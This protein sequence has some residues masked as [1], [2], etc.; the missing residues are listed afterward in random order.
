MTPLDTASVSSVCARCAKRFN[1]CCA[2]LPGNEEVCFPLSLGEAQRMSD[3]GIP[4]QSVESQPNTQPFIDCM[5][6]LFPADTSTIE[7]TFPLGKVHLR[8]ASDQEGRCKLLSPS[9]CMLPGE[10]RPWYCRL[11]PFWFMPSGMLTMFA[12]KQCLVYL[13]SRSVRHAMDTLDVKEHALRLLFSNLRRAWDLGPT[14]DLK[15]NAYPLCGH[16]Q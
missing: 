7:S 6:R 10:A 1:S 15:G 12:S 13:E 8:L 2:M 11:F 16:T 3:H 4:P 5:N 14:H 9:G